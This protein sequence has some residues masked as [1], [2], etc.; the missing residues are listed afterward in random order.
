MKKM[1]LSMASIALIFVASCKKDS[2]ENAETEQISTVDETM[3]NDETAL[4][5]AYNDAVIKLEE[6]KKSGD[7]VA[8]AAA[9]E[10]LDKAKSSWEMAKEKASQFSVHV[11]ED[12]T[13]ATDKIDAAA[14]KAKAEIKETATEAK[15]SIN[16]T[17]EDAA[18]N[19]AKAKE[20]VRQ[21][22]NNTLDKMKAK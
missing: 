9:Q 17:K 14:D 21:G 1:I 2:S 10:V 13:T 5:M 11:K 16:K 15:E 6:A 4:E 7:A 18:N 22:Y 3:D 20:D 12:A 8:Q 19:A